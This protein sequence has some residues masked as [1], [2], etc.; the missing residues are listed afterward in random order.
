MSAIVC[1]QVPWRA[2]STLAG[3]VQQFPQAVVAHLPVSVNGTDPHGR[4]FVETTIIELATPAEVLFCS[5]LP[6]AAGDEFRIADPAGTFAVRATVVA[7]C[8]RNGKTAVAAR[9]TDPDQALP[10]RKK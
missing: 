1:K 4:A 6:F 8:Y 3:L 10:V 9:L 2:S 7:A 5:A